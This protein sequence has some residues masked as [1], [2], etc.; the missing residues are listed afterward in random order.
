MYWEYIGSLANE[1][2]DKR[3]SSIENGEVD[4]RM[5]A[6]TSTSLYSSNNHQGTSNSSLNCLVMYVCCICLDDLRGQL[7]SSEEKV[8]QLTEEMV[9][10]NLEQSSLKQELNSLRGKEAI[11]CYL[12]ISD[13]FRSIKRESYIGTR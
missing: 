4:E 1:T 9:G 8:K 7:N 3:H 5:S 11:I 12:F 6:V 2:V 10:F 13:H